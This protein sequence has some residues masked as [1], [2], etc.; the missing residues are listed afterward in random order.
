MLWQS[1]HRAHWPKNAPDIPSRLLVTVTSHTTKEF[2]ALYSALPLAQRQAAQKAYALW[3]S[4]PTH[5]SLQYK[6]IHDKLPV[7]S[8]RI[9]IGWRA[10]GVRD[11]DE[12]TWF[13]I[14]SHASYD[15]LIASL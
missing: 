7:Y 9:S 8:V 10:V 14:G 11:K 6:K 15:R 12:M 13:F 1:W 2:R 5:S 3:R 4:D